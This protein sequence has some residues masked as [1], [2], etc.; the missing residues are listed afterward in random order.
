MALDVHWRCYACCAMQRSRLS[1]SAFADVVLM[2]LRMRA[3]EREENDR[4]C[5]LDAE[6]ETSEGGLSESVRASGRRECGDGG[7]GSYGWN[8]GCWDR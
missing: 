7:Y 4:E 5:E 1:L 3:G 2:P 6:A 8:G